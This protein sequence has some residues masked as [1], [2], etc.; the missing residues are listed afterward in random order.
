LLDADE[1][2]YRAY[3]R[4]D[5][6]PVRKWEDIAGIEKSDLEPYSTVILD[7]AGRALDKLT[8]DIIAGNP[9]LGRGGALT[10]QGYGELKARFIAWMKMVN[11]FGKDVVLLCHMDEQR[12]GD[13]IIERLDVQGGS[14]G[15]I[16]KSV[17]AMAKL[18]VEGKGYKLDF[19][20]RENAYGKN[21]GQFPILDIP[22][23]MPADCLANIMQQ[24]KE[25]LNMMG[26]EQEAAHDLIEKWTEKVSKLTT[27]D[28]FNHI[29]PD[30]TQSGTVVKMLLHKEATLKG[31]VFNR[32]T[33][34]YESKQEAPKQTPPVLFPEKKASEPVAAKQEKVMCSECRAIDGHK[35]DCKFAVK[36][37][38]EKRTAQLQKALYLV[39]SADQK[40]KMKKGDKKGVPTGDTYL[41]LKVVASTDKGDVEGLLY[42]WRTPLFEH[43][44]VGKIDKRLVAEVSTQQK[45]DKTYIQLEH[46]LEL[47]GVP[48]VNDAPAAQAQMPTADEEVEQELFGPEA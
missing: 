20:P 33:G 19:S 41:V 11:G 16:Y 23:P 47:G 48:F 32:T 10:L 14:K 36:A 44:P 24:I 43:F 25:R 4:K 27:A 34:L 6:V 40:K 37:E 38:Q 45:D 3:G 18:Y 22:Y 26:V 30:V 7:T 15:E 8:S 42:C 29:I 35:P 13:D 28:E 2:A 12:R 21:P 1:G 46:V 39:L 5:S 31:F 9:K 17:D